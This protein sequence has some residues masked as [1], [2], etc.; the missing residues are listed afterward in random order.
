MTTHEAVQIIPARYRTAVVPHILVADGSAALS[1]YKEAFG[2]VE[3]FR[4]DA[5]EGG[6][7]HA[8]MRIG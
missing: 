6:V 8:E 4:I 3:D 7:L 1:F 5:P 2:A